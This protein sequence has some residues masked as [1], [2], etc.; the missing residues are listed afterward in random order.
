M[1][2]QPWIQLI[3]IGGIAY[4]FHLWWTDLKAFKQGSPHPKAIQ[5]AS[6]CNWS[7]SIIGVVGALIIL[8]METGGEILLGISEEQKDITLLFGLV[9]LFAP[10][11]EEIAFRGY[12][13]IDKKGKAMLI[14]SIL[15]CSVIFTL[16]HPFLWTY[17][18]KSLEFHFTAKAWFTS[19]ILLMNS[20]WFYYLRFNA[21][22]KNR[23][24]IPCFAAHFSS[25]LGV[26]IIKAS[27]GHL[28]GLI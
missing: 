17:E 12:L 21:R 4:L 14:L 13:Y 3:F 16:C 5:G 6:T 22:N 11:G 28:V 8:A 10:I 24:L 15:A 23:S 18:D 7:V 26:V 1:N 19:A 25:N 20:L 27:Q 2:D 9:T